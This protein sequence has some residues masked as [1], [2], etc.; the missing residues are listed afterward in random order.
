MR[1]QA[2]SLEGFTALSAICVVSLDEEFQV[3]LRSV[4]LCSRRYSQNI[5][6]KQGY[7]IVSLLLN[8]NAEDSNTVGKFT[9][10]CKSQVMAN[11][12]K[13]RNRSVQ[14]HNPSDATK[15]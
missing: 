9:V 5:N 4:I 6:L 11:I 12:P 2:F 13:I 1:S 15:R 8:V 3:V 14:C 7:R 10:R